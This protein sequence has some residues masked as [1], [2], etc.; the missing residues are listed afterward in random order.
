MLNCANNTAA[1]PI[2]SSM[3]QKLQ[4]RLC[5]ATAGQTHDSMHQLCMLVHPGTPMFQSSRRCAVSYCVSMLSTEIFVLCED[6]A[7]GGYD[8]AWTSVRQS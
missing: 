4:V 1:Q 8:Q 5:I 6:A 2:S 7:Q 3:A